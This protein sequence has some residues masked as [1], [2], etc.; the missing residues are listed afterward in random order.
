MPKPR[1]S[2]ADRR[3][4]KRKFDE[5]DLEKH[6]PEKYRRVWRIIQTY[7]RPT[8]EED[9]IYPDSLPRPLHK[10]MKRYYRA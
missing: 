5:M 4:I 7:G 6:G 9:I 3:R 1:Q 10:R 8:P 2:A